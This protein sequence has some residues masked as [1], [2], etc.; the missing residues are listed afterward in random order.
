[1]ARACFADAYEA[2]AAQTGLDTL[3]LST[4]NA[5]VLDAR[6]RGA[7]SS[8]TLRARS[9]E[10]DPIPEKVASLQLH[11]RE[12]RDADIERL[13]A[14]LET[15]TH[16]SLRGTPVSEDFIEAIVSRWELRSLDI[17]DTP[18]G[19]ECVLRIRAR[20]PRLRTLPNPER[21]RSS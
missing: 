7:L 9:I 8:L 20:Y 10:G 12:A 3:S 17:V 21:Q 5:L 16:L 18:V 15:V 4:E 6:L 19:D 14:R 2:S 11:V 13:L 1:M